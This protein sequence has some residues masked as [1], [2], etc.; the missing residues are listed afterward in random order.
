[1]LILV[2]LE[3]NFYFS[4]SE[5]VAEICWSLGFDG[6]NAARETLERLLKSAHPIVRGRAHYC[7]AFWY[8]RH[9]GTDDPEIR[10]HMLSLY[11]AVVA[12]Y[13]DVTLFQRRLG[14]ESK[15][16]LYFLNNLLVGMKA[17]EIVS[18]DT[19]GILFRLSDYHGKVILPSFLGH[20][21]GPCMVMVPHERE[22]LDTMKGRPFT[23]IG[24]NS[25]PDRAQIPKL[26]YDAGITWRSFWNGP[27]GMRGPISKKWNVEG[28]PT[29]YLIDHKGVI[30]YFWKNIPE[31]S[32]L[33]KAVEEVLTQVEQVQ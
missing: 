15:Q 32:S 4:E 12:D 33:G 13:S 3:R 21:C 31:I 30:R 1:M 18:E 28:W 23:I 9:R 5:V 10:K 25:D 20:W 11:E 14:P 17:P 6:S 16:K 27:G 2:S 29:F 22:L 19:N 7:L 26:N 8:D 24:V